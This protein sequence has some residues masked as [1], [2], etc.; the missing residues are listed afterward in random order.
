MEIKCE[1]NENNNKEM[2]NASL[3]SENNEAIDLKIQIIDKDTPI[4]QAMETDKLSLEVLMLENQESTT[5]DL[6][7]NQNWTK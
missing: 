4:N 6:H 7:E 5:F 1:N 3:F 2:M